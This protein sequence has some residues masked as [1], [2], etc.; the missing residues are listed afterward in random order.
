LPP[1]DCF[2]AATAQLVKTNSRFVRNLGTAGRLLKLLPAEEDHGST[3]MAA[4]EFENSIEEMEEELR[5][6]ALKIW[7]DLRQPAYVS[8]SSKANASKTRSTRRKK[9]FKARNAA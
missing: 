4:Q 9:V 3:A 6:M 2:G 8:E 5:K 1:H 7:L